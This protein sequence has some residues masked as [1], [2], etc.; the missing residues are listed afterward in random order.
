[1]SHGKLDALRNAGPLILPSMLMCNFGN[2]ERELGLL[3]DA[4]VQGYHL[5]VMDGV[6]VPNFTY[7]MT[8]VAAIRKLTKLPLDVHLMMQNPLQYIDDFADAGADIITF[9]AEAVGDP[10]PVI[11]RI[12]AR[13]LPAGIAINSKTAVSKIEAVLPRCEMALLMSIEAGFGGQ[14]FEEH[15]L[16]KFQQVRDI[17]GPE[18]VLEVDGGINK[19]T[20]RSAA[21]AGAELLVVGSAI[22]RQADYKEALDELNSVVG[23]STHRVTPTNGL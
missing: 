12:H 3:E 2:L 4:G 11:E 18:I 19:E 21:E 5:D 16:G 22:F 13:G 23:N 15:V 20:I 14:K 8:I 1:M 6:F 9:H 7:G 17:A 10:L